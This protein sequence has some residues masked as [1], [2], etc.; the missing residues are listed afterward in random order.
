MGNPS[1]SEKSLLDIGYGL[2][3]GLKGLSI[4]QVWAKSG[5]F[6]LTDTADFFRVVVLLERSYFEAQSVLREFAEQQNAED[7]FPL[8]KVVGAGLAS[9]S[10]QWTGLALMW[11]PHL[12]AAEK[13]KLES[14]LVD[15]HSAKWA[16]QKSRQLADLYVKQIRAERA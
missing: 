13:A 4:W 1:F 6:D 5:C 14:L 16:S 3:I 15:I 9:Q 8:W 12:P 10:D 7:Q 2:R 11:V